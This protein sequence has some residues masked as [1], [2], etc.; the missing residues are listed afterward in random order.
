MRIGLHLQGREADP[1]PFSS[2]QISTRNKG[3]KCGDDSDE[4]RNAKRQTVHVLPKAVSLMR[5]VLQ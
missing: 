3:V 4:R 1:E 2:S 5:S